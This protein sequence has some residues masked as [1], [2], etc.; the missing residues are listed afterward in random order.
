MTFLPQICFYPSEFPMTFLVSTT[1][2]PD[3]VQPNLQI[4]ILVF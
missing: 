1:N 3:S 2:I 4:A